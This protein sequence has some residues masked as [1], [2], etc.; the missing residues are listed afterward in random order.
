M[1]VKHKVQNN[2]FCFGFQFKKI[3]Y[4]EVITVKGKP[5]SFDS[6]NLSKTTRL[7]KKWKGIRM[8]A[9]SSL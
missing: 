7:S 1:I 2:V 8:K 4:H 3:K 5:R 9:K 6:G